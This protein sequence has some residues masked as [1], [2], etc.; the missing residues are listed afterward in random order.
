MPICD[1]FILLPKCPADFA[2]ERAYKRGEK[3]CRLLKNS[4]FFPVWKFECTVIARMM[5]IGWVETENVVDDFCF[6]SRHHILEWTTMYGVVVS[7]EIIDTFT[8]EFSPSTFSDPVDQ[9][10][11]VNKWWAIQNSRSASCVLKVVWG[12]LWRSASLFLWIPSDL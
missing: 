7:L 3:R 9:F 2:V 5:E 1:K 11:S 6:D 12:Q 10:H 8:Q 4:T